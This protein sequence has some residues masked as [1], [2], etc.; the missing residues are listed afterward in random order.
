MID[1]IEENDD[2]LMKSIAKNSLYV[3]KNKVMT[4]NK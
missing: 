3:E 1:K 4:F 2:N